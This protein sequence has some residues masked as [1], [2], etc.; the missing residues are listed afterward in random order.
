MNKKLIIVILVIS[1]I[2]AAI[3]VLITR[4][5]KPPEIKVIAVDSYNLKASGCVLFH[6]GI[7]N[8]ESAF[9]DWHL[10]TADGSVELFHGLLNL[11]LKYICVEDLQDW[12]RLMVFQSDGQTIAGMMAHAMCGKNVLCYLTTKNA[13]LSGIEISAEPLVV[14]NE[15]VNRTFP[16]SKTPGLITLPNTIPQ[17]SKP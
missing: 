8:D 4:K 13:L 6:N 10:E 11:P 7:N 14:N 16:Y 5:T 12:N 2:A 17:R 1:I 15:G 3:T 9:Q